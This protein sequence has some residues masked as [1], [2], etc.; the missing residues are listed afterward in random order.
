MTN[1]SIRIL[2]AA[3]LALAAAGP[4]RAQLPATPRALGT[5]GAYLGAARGYESLFTNPANLA[6]P[7]APRWSL[8]LPQ[9]AASG[10]LLGPAFKDVPDLLRESTPDARQDQILG[11]IPASGTE[12]QYDLRVPLGAIQVGSL[13]VGVGYRSIGGHSLGKDI[14]ELLAKGYDEARTDYSVGNTAGSRATYYDA[15]MGYGR[16]VGPLS[17]G[18][19][20]HY[21]R[22]GTVMRSRMFEP[23]V[24]VEARDVSVD[25][26]SVLARGGSGYSLDLGAALQPARGV[27]LSAAVEN[28]ASHM[29][30]TEDLR[31]RDMRVSRTELDAGSIGE[32]RT[33]YE[34]TEKVLDSS[35]VPSRVYETAQGLYDGAFLPAVARMGLDWAP[36]HGSSIGGVYQRRLTSGD[37]DGRWQTMA[38]AG[39]QQK[40]LFL[41]ARAGLASNLDGA[42]MVTGGLSLGPIHA[43]VARLHDGKV[44][45]AERAGYAVSLGLDVSSR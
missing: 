18:A 22:G 1:R 13:A 9:L 17:V 10:T 31:Y 25:Y 39:V 12:A 21:L 33:R 28:A 35:A 32:L 5:A 43:A 26:V 6:L 24:D 30:W 42:R 2:A 14:V 4:A 20:A 19:T 23:R 7:G 29:S 38:A 41:T 16:R 3:S 44:D 15:A 45:G 36:R 27:T 8:A 37:L 11:T 34:G 40:L